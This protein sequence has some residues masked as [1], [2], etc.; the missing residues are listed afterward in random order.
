VSGWNELVK[1]A[2][3]EIEEKEDREEQQARGSFRPARRSQQ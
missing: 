3:D 1:K 2:W